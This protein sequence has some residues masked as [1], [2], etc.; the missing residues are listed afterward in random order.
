[1]LVCAPSPG[2]LSSSL[3]SAVQQSNPRARLLQA[4]DRLFYAQGYSTTGINQILAE[5]GVAKASLYAHFG[6]KE[7]LAVAYLQGR[8]RRWFSELGEVV[9]RRRTPHTR[10]LAPFAFLANWL[11]RVDFRG[12]AFLNVLGEQPL[13]EPLQ[14]QVRAHKSELR[15]YFHALVCAMGLSP[16]Q[17]RNVSDALLLVFDGAIVQCQVHHDLWP[18]NAAARSAAQLL[19]ATHP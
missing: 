14:A 8:H 1:M 19:D 6:T 10:A 2:T 12:C 3:V 15:E 7:E 5:A 9:D 16:S 4:A 18:A 11:V 17:A 13:P